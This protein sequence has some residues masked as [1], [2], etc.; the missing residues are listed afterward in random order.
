LIRR[1]VV[2]G[3]LGGSPTGRLVTAIFMF[4][5]WFVYIILC[6]MQA[7]NIGG[8][9]DITFGVDINVANKCNPKNL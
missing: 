6:T 9:G 5:L 3:E 7:Y 2:G 1:C 8:L 4:F